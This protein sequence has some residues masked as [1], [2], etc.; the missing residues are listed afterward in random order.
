MSFAREIVGYDFKKS[1]TFILKSL[2]H[3]S[4]SFIIGHPST[5]LYLKSSH[6]SFTSSNSS[7]SHHLPRPSPCPPLTNPSSPSP[8]PH[9]SWP[10]SPYPPTRPSP[11]SPPPYAEPNTDPRP[12]SQSLRTSAVVRRVL[13]CVSGSRRR[14]QRIAR[15]E[16]GRG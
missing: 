8:H 11:P 16:V 5:R 15:R 9:I 10:H 2:S 4:S 3:P 12:R 7:P 13:Q 6:L 1:T 14:S